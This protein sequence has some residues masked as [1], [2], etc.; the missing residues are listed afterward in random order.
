MAVIPQL[1]SWRKASRIPAVNPSDTPRGR[2]R[3]ERSPQGAPGERL[4]DAGARLALPPML[5]HGFLVN[6]Y[7]ISSLTFL[8]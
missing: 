4:K 3:R 6:D 8:F 1:L 2:R 5:P 7:S